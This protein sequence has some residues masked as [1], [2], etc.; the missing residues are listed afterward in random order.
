MP[1]ITQDKWKMFKNYMHNE[2]G[3]T[4]EDIKDWVKEAVEEVAE[5]LVN[6]E[7]EKYP[8]PNIIKKNVEVVLIEHSLWGD[9]FKNEIWNEVGNQ[10]S[11]KL[12]IKLKNE[13]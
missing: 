13:E 2:L 8:L 3:I 11:K 1:H 7:F 5:S 10:I 6:Q 9:D 4:K 12:E